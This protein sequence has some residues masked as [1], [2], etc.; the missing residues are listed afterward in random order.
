M[1]SG[2]VA[3]LSSKNHF[4]RSIENTLEPRPITQI[5]P[6]GQQTYEEEDDKARSKRIAVWRVCSLCIDAVHLCRSRLACARSI[7]D[8]SALD[9]EP[10]RVTRPEHHT[11]AKLKFA[12]SRGTKRGRNERAHN[13]R[14]SAGGSSG[15]T[16]DQPDVSSSVSHSH[17][18]SRCSVLVFGGTGK[19][20]RV[21][22]DAEVIDLTN[23]SVRPMNTGALTARA[24]HTATL[25]TD[26]SILFAGGVDSNGATLNSLEVW[27]FRTGTCSKLPI[28]LQTA[29]RGHEAALLAN[30]SVLIWGGVDA[31]GNP[32]VPF[33]EVI[34]PQNLTSKPHL[35]WSESD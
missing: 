35:V 21:V 20:N 5:E 24:Y 15:N 9:R 28:Q 7:G 10:Q 30:G 13:S 31:Y 32:P 22:P 4:T 6:D 34:D 27:N 33:G 23:G 19:G 1:A 2:L 12:L 16:A 29:R 11:F 17:T 18:A 14:K 25:L 3:T 8:P 26:G